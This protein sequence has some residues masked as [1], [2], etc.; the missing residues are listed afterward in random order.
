MTFSR[1]LASASAVV[2]LSSKVLSSGVM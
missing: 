2:I 1:S